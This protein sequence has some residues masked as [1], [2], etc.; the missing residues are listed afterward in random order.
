LKCFYKA[1]AQRARKSLIHL[2]EDDE[3]AS[4]YSSSSSSESSSSDDD[5]PVKKTKFDKSSRNLADKLAKKEL[6]RE[7]RFEESREVVNDLL[8]IV[9]DEK[10][11]Q[12]SISFMLWRYKHYEYLMMGGSSVHE[13]MG[14]LV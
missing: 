4:D 10:I 7:R 12:Y 1:Y 13:K 9:I 3:G 11:L 6:R 2:L 8:E 14:D 5:E